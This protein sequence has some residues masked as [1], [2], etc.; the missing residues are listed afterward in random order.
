MKRKHSVAQSVA[1]QDE[2]RHTI[3]DYPSVPNIEWFQCFSKHSTR[4]GN[5]LKSFPSKDRFETWFSSAPISW[6]RAVWMRSIWR[7]HRVSD[8]A[9]YKFSL[10]LETSKGKLVA[11]AQCLCQFCCQ[12]FKMLQNGNRAQRGCRIVVA[13]K[14][15]WI[16]D[17]FLQQRKNIYTC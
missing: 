13:A 16:M 12:N 10:N 15:V 14:I 17:K 3:M 6:N 2:T 1:Q 4:K 5:R 11:L 7:R 8:N 9:I